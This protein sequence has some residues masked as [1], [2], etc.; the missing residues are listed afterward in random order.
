MSIAIETRGLTYRTGK[1]FELR[2]VD[3]NVPAG[4]LY[5]FL[6]PNGSGKTTTIRLL[7]GMLRPNAGSISVLGSSVP[8]D[9][10]RV[11]ARTGY[12]PERPHV[13]PMLTVEE[14]MRYHASF[15]PSWDWKW[16]EELAAT[17]ALTRRSKIASLS[18]G[19]SGK[20]LMLLA[21]AQRPELLIL[22]E[23]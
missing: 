15:Y 1:G 5:G 18:K 12:V 17:F 9:A 3:L 7:L 4:A 23:P 6:G 20:L 14:A 11:M 8:Q 2:D 21:L 10:P 19:E 22:D 16:A 13:Y